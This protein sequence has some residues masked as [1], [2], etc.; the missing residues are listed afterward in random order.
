MNSTGEL[1][2]IPF[3]ALFDGEK[4]LVE[5]FQISN[6][7]GVDLIRLAKNPTQSQIENINTVIFANPTQESAHYD[8]PDLPQ[9]ENEAKYMPED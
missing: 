5:K 8:L 9:S 4:Y 3:G 2:Y 6:V 7:T 1:R